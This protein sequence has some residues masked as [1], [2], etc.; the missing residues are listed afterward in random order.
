MHTAVTIAAIAYWLRGGKD[1]A[2]MTTKELILTFMIPVA[3]LVA[4]IVED[5]RA[6]F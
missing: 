6:V 1:V 5:I 4:A 3:C 2:R